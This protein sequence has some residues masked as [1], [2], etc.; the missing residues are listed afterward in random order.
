MF[1]SRLKALALGVAGLAV[2]ACGMLFSADRK[3]GVATRLLPDTAPTAEAPKPKVSAP[4]AYKDL[5]L[6]FVSRDGAAA[7]VFGDRAD[8]G[9]GVKYKYRYESADGKNSKVGEGLVVELRRLDGMG[10]DE[11]LLDIKAGPITITWSAGN[12]DRGWIYYVPE[13]VMVHIAH[14][15]HFE[16]NVRILGPNKIEIKALDLKR[17]MRK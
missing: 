5:M 2:L 13:T 12:M 10:Y 6:V 1:A 11:T 15:D 8:E 17:F 4:V 7:V 14:A 9:K 3:V 16:N